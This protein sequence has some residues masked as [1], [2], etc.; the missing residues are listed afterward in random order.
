MLLLLQDGA[1]DLVRLW[2]WW[3]CVLMLFIRRWR[4]IPKMLKLLID[5]LG[6]G[7]AEMRCKMLL[8]VLLMLQMRWQLIGL[9]YHNALL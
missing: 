2:W 9:E 6:E 3:R 1:V 4:L 5:R 7:N 8:Q